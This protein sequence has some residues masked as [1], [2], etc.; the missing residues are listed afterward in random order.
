MGSCARCG[1]TLCRQLTV[2]VVERIIDQ[3]A[4]IGGRDPAILYAA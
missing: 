2:Y 3:I 1:P 4:D